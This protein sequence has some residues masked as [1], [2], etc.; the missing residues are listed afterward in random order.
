MLLQRCQMQSSQRLS[1]Q[2]RPDPIGTGA[3][4]HAHSKCREWRET[5][6]GSLGHDVVGPGSFQGY[7]CM[8]GSLADFSGKICAILS[9][10]TVILQFPWC[11]T[12]KSHWLLQLRYTKMVGKHFLRKFLMDAS[13][14]FKYGFACGFLGLQPPAVDS[15]LFGVLR[16]WSET[17]LLNSFMD[18]CPAYE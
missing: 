3:R 5:P 7:L 13:V 1:E 4:A 8:T 11:Y 16:V 10:Y 15:L 17:Q 12:C 2:R 6:A 18:H 9:A 14:C